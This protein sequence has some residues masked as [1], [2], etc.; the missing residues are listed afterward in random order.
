MKTKISNYLILDQIHLYFIT[1]SMYSICIYIQLFPYKTL[2]VLRHSR[3]FQTHSL[4][5]LYL[6][7]AQI[8]E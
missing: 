8:T 7:S 5:T 1:L 3:F 4:M 2:I 6:N